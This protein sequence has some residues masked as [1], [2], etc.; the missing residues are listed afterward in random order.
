MD[1]RLYYLLTLSRVVIKAKLFEIK[2]EIT[3]IPSTTLV[4]TVLS[5][6]YSI[7]RQ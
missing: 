3:L 4:C 5:Y 7:V 1:R 6:K 2:G